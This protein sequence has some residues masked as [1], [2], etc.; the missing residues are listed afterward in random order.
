[1]IVDADFLRTWDD[2]GH[3]YGECM[4]HPNTDLMYVY[5]P[6]NA[7]SWTKPNLQ[8]FGWEFYNYHTDGLNKHAMVVLRDPVDRWL[9]GIAEYLTL[10][11]TNLIL[12][13]NILN[14]IFDRICF[15]DHTDRQVNFIHGLD[16]DNCTFFRCDQY[17]RDDFSTF[18]DEHNMPNR[19]HRYEFQHVSKLSPV[20]DGFKNIFL[21]EITNPKYLQAVKDYFSA[22]YELIN[23]VKFYGSR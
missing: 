10:Y 8:D 16:T 18:L 3:V 20:R 17:Y 9:S 22:D 19:Y 23:S 15:D 7:S 5:I 11:H 14:L 2:K 12:E 4:S 1:V 6:K 21:R 13:P